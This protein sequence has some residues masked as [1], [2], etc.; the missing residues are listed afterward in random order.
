MRTCYLLKLNE[1]QPRLYFSLSS[2]P[3]N[4]SPISPSLLPRVCLLC[5]SWI[6]LSLLQPA[7]GL[8]EI[9]LP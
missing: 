7:Q 1:C 3:E 2:V 8:V 4:T 5:Q 9:Q 6:A